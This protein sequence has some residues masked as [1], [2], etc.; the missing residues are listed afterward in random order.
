MRSAV[1]FA[2]LVVLAF[3]CASVSDLR[4]QS[5][6]NQSGTGG[7]NEIQRPCLSAERKEPG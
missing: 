6:T 4:G 2:V 7:I 5:G 3:F 1:F